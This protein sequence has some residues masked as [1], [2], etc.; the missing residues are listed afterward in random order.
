M[1]ILAKCDEQY[2]IVSILYFQY[3][4]FAFHNAVLYF[5]RVANSIALARTV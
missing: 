4:V 3:T 2:I 5:F 1:E